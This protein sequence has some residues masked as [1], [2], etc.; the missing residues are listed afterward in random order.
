MHIHFMNQA[1]FQAEK[2]ESMGEVPVGAVLV[3]NNEIISTGHN[4]V[5]TNNDPT[6]HAEIVVIRKASHLIQNYRIVDSELYITLEPCSMCYSAIINSRISRII[7]GAHDTKTGACGTCINLSQS[8]CFNH[9]PEII[10]GV[11]E[12]ECSEILRNFFRQR[13]L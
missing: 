12:S 10:G 2:A 8:K 4:L 9:K 5:I 7:Y 1:L 3:K 11:L 6:A 13:R